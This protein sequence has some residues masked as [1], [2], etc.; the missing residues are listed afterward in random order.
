VGWPPKT[1]VDNTGE[2][3]G[4]QHRPSLISVAVLRDMAGINVYLESIRDRKKAREQW[5]TCRPVAGG[6]RPR[7]AAEV[8]CLE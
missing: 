3:S 8:D 5:D 2:A 1:F 6:Q 7:E 4:S